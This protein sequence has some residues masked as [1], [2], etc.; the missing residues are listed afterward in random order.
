[1]ANYS[2]LVAL[3]RR[4]VGFP[5]PEA[6]GDDKLSN[7]VILEY[8]N[9]AFDQMAD[10]I[11]GFDAY[12]E[13]TIT[14]AGVIVVTDPTTNP[15]DVAATAD[16]VLGSYPVYTVSDARSYRSGENKSADVLDDSRRI[17]VNKPLDQSWLQA[18][19]NSTVRFY[20]Y[21]SVQGTR[22]F[23]LLPLT[24][25]ETNT[26][27]ITYGKNF[28]RYAIGDVAFTGAGLDDMTQAGIYTAND[29]VTTNYRVEIDGNAPDTFQ[30][31]NDGGATW[32]A[33]GVAVDTAAVTLENGLTVT[34]GALLGHTIGEHWDWA[35]TAPGLT[36][37]KEEEQRGFPVLRA[38]AECGRD[39]DEARYWYWLLEAQGKNY[40]REVEGL[41]GAFMEKHLTEDLLLN[42]NLADPYY[43]Q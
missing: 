2:E 37:M 15:P 27:G 1:M 23:T 10:A 28:V 25:T 38:A 43:L 3:V 6:G 22:G 42:E 26:I 34:F 16:P 36:V 35:A 29:G 11:Y 31:S 21:F 8:L 41:L 33:T 40:P 17:M 30:W 19:Y 20:K 9:N 39:L 13:F 4:K 32:E 5:E 18:T 14:A 7:A 24:I 12:V